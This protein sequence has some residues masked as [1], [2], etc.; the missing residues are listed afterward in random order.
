MTHN[1]HK[2]K[3]C[4]KQG[5]EGLWL[6][7]SF[8][9]RRVSGWQVSYDQFIEEKIFFLKNSQFEICLG[10]TVD[11]IVIVEQTSLMSPIRTRTTDI[12]YTAMFVINVCYNILTNLMYSKLFSK[13]TIARE[14][15]ALLCEE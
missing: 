4:E 6:E 14:K 7:K 12:F 8:S 9:T 13:A 11:P 5:I 15:A 10:N 2:I 1:K 3:T